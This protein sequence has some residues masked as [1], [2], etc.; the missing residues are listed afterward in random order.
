MDKTFEEVHGEWF[1]RHWKESVGVRRRL[2]ER[3]VEKREKFG[4][5]GAET[6]FLRD[7][8]WPEFGQLEDLHPEYETIDVLGRTRFL[9]FAYIRFPLLVDVEIDGF[10]PHLKNVSRYDFADERRR[11]AALGVMGWRVLRFSYDDV[12]ENPLLCRELLKRWMEAAAP[13]EPT[14]SVVRER[15]I[16]MCLYQTSFGIN[17]VIRLLG[18]SENPARNLLRRMLADNV[19]VSLNGNRRRVH[20]YGLHESYR[21]SFLNPIMKYK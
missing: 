15:V 10:G 19:L 18:W 1:R 21:R 9:D 6:R 8:W 11:D 12:K 20:R 14:E 5:D 13:K 17:D 7:V 16:R 2:L 3:R 4:E